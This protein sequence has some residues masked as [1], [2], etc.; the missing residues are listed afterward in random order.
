LTSSSS[1]QGDPKAKGWPNELDEGKHYYIT[2]VW[3]VVGSCENDAIGKWFKYDV[4]TVPGK[5]QVELAIK[6]AETGR[7]APPLLPNERG[8]HC[9]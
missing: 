7:L 5:L 9:E 2:A 4:I 6:D 3:L 1:S 8:P